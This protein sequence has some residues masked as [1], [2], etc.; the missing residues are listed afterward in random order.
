MSPIPPVGNIEHKPSFS[1]GPVH[2]HRKCNAFTTTPRAIQD[3]LS[4]GLWSTDRKR[5]MIKGYSK[6]NNQRYNAT[7]KIFPHN[8]LKLDVFIC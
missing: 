3:N 4:F 1:T 6:P 5:K 8:Y 2:K 7:G